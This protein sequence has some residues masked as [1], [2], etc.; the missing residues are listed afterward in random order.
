MFSRVKLP[1]SPLK[2]RIDMTFE[3]IVNTRRMGESKNT[4]MAVYTDTHSEVVKVCAELN[5]SKVKFLD[6]ALRKLMDEYYRKVVTPDGRKN[7]TVK[8]VS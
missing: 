4:T 2:E 1:A 5:C 6:L 8:K 7:N 3:S